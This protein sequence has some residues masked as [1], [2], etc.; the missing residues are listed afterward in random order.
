MLEILISSTVLILA[1]TALRFFLRGKLNPRLQYTLWLLAALRLLL[2]VS[3]VRSPVSVMNAVPDVPAAVQRLTAPE[4]RRAPQTDST[5]A[6]VQTTS[7]PETA[8]VE[9][10]T[11]LTSKYDFEICLADR[12]GGDGACCSGAESAV[13]PET[14]KNPAAV[15]LPGKPGSGLAG[16]W[17]AVAVP[18][19]AVQA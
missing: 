2:P 6:P 5:Q 17:P 10:Q 3:L 18:R 4:D 15:C 8:P 12:R 14:E 1:L 9:V 13:S 7:E 16:L 11:R 19:G